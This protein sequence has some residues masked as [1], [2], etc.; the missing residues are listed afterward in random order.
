MATTPIAMFIFASPPV[1]PTLKIYD[2]N[3]PNSAV[4][5]SISL[6]PD[7]QAAYLW[8]GEITENITGDK[9]CHLTNGDFNYNPADTPHWIHNLKDTTDLQFVRNDPPQQSQL[10]AR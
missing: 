2:V 5:A 8:R 9:Y 10:E 1:S 4:E 6:S 3:T 7:G